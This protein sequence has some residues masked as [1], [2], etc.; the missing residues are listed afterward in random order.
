MKVL[1]FGSSGFIGRHVAESLSG[2]HGVVRASHD[3]D[4]DDGVDLADFGSVVGIINRDKPDVIVNCAGIVANDERAN[5][6]VVFSDNILRAVEASDLLVRRVVVMGSAAEYGVV[7]PEELPVGEDTS[8]R[9]ESPYGKSKVAETNRALE[10]RDH[11]L[12][13]VV[14][15]VFNPV[16]PGM[17]ERM[18]VPRILTQLIDIRMGRQS[19]LEISRLDA[20]RDYIA[21]G[22]VA[23]GIRTLVEGEPEHAV[24]NIGS[25]VAT[26]NGRLIDE[27]VRQSG[28]KVMPEIVETLAQP[29][30]LYAPQADISRLTAMG[31]RPRHSLEEVIEE[32]I[33]A[34][35]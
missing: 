20:L 2:T 27:I 11:G 7:L 21:V 23:E 35:E 18:I 3:R 19:H 10:Y 5:Q 33:H 16:G 1:V 9:A 30:P 29:E 14:A 17:P 25:G 22:D 26:S 28:L 15:R 31:W 34:G 8:L 12:S 6:N 24:Y 4:G 13:V 32:I